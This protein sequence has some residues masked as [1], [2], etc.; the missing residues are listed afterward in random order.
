V[1]EDCGNIGCD[2]QKTEKSIR[3]ASGRK[4]T[5]ESRATQFRKRLIVWKQT[6]EFLRP[7]LRELARQLGTSHQLL[8]HYLA[9]L[10]A[11]KAKERYNRAKEMAQKKADEA[12]ARAKAENRKMTLSSLLAVISFRHTVP[13]MVASPFSFWFNPPSRCS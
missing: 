8:Q 10:E 9:G 1:I 3:T 5:H 6:P 7:S 2:T 4:P 13:E 12:R 11:W